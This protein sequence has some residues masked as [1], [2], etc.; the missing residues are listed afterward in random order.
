MNT[1]CIECRQP[2]RRV[3][4]VTEHVPGDVYSAEGD[5]ETQISGMCEFC[6]DDAFSDLDD[7]SDGLL[8]DFDAWVAQH[9]DDESPNFR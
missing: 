4:G 5:A 9:D 1:H 3:G 8:N 7:E 2:F 6:F